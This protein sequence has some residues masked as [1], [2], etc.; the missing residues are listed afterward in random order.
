MTEQTRIETARAADTK[1]AVLYRM[2]MPE[3]I[4]PW[5]LRARHLLRS[6]GYE[7]EDHWLTT[8]EENERFKAEHG[9]K[10]TP[11]VFIGGERVG[12]YDD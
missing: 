12:G 9:V 10:T 5:G 6:K 1:R 7:V 3:H 4:C 2:V 11:Q 8:K